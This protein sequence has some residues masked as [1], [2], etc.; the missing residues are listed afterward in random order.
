MN[1]FTRWRDVT[2]DFE[3][4]LVALRLRAPLNQDGR[5]IQRKVRAWRRAALT[6]ID[7]QIGYVKGQDADDPPD[8][9]EL[10]E[11]AFGE[12]WARELFQRA[13]RLKEPLSDDD[14]QEIAGGAALFDA[15]GIGERVAILYKLDDLAYLRGSEGKA[16]SSPSTSSVETPGGTSASTATPTVPGDGPAR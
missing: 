13:V 12:A 11:R 8:G 7:A 2:I 10:F 3:G 1:L 5:E 4:V 6:S 16:S 15:M 14:G 9:Y